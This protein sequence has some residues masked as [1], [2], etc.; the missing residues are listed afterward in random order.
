MF[1]FFKKRKVIL[2]LGGG[3]ARAISNIGVLKVLEQEKIP[4]DYIIGTSMG[5]IVGAAYSVGRS[6]S[7]MVQRVEQF[8]AEE[9]TDL[10]LSRSAFTKGERLNR[11]INEVTDGKSFSDC[12]IP[13][14]ATATDLNTGEE[15]LFKSEDD[16]GNLQKI[17]QASCSWPAFFP[18]IEFNGKLLA[19]GGIK[20]SVPVK[21]ARKMLKMYA[22][23]GFNIYDSFMGTGTTAEACIVEKMNYIGSELS[24]KQ[25]DFANKRIKQRLSE[26]TLFQ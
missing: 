19:D 16:P 7:Y 1:N 13:F 8:N 17:V 15:F 14:A 22:K 9:I 3:A 11:F 24:K 2:C 18:P 21:F 6:V 20:N 25:C 5:A 23:E 26:P 10:T 4:I 12:K